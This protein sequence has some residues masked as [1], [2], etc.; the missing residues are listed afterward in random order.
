M[1]RD[2]VVEELNLAWKLGE[3]RQGWQLDMVARNIIEK[4][5]YGKY[6]VHR[7]GHSIGPGPTLHGLGVNLDN[8][9]THDIRNVLPGIGFS[10][11]PG[12]I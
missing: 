9:E 1:P 2:S 6:F 11:E 4:E 5:G 12:I 3:R 8:L 7:T 10:V